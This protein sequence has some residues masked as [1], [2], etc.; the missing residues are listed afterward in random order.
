MN[1]L[2]SCKKKPHCQTHESMGFCKEQETPKKSKDLCCGCY[3]EDYHYG[4][5]GA[6]ECFYFDDAT[7]IPRIPIASSL[8]PPYSLKNVQLMFDCYRQNQMVYVSPEALT[9]E[10]YWRH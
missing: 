5:G 8:A 7:V 10:G 4:L 3:N 6:K 1:C 9:E 2:P